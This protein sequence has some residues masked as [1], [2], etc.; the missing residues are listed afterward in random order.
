MLIPIKFTNRCWFPLRVYR[1]SWYVVTT[2]V[3]EP[4]FGFLLLSFS[5][6]KQNP[7]TSQFSV[8]VVIVKSNF[9]LITALKN[10]KITVLVYLLKTG[11]ITM[12]QGQMHWIH[13][14]MTDSTMCYKRQLSVNVCIK[15]LG[16]YMKNI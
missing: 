5:D 13:L 7:H 3:E 1:F 15:I 12:C 11:R 14:Y 4:S 8:R 6:R 9:R 2:S 16:D 10:I